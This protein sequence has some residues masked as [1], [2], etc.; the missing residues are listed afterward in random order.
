MPGQ[1]LKKKL[2]I[3][4]QGSKGNEDGLPDDNFKALFQGLEEYA[5][6]FKMHHINGTMT[7]ILTS[8]TQSDLQQMG[9]GSVGHQKILLRRITDIQSTELQSPWPLGE[10]QR[11]R[12]TLRSMRKRVANTWLRCLWRGFLSAEVFL[13]G[14]TSKEETFLMNSGVALFSLLV[15]FAMANW[16]SALRNVFD[17]SGA[18]TILIASENAADI[19]GWALPACHIGFLSGTI[20]SVIGAILAAQSNIMLMQV[21][22]DDFNEFMSN[23]GN[24]AQQLMGTFFFAGLWILLATFVFMAFCTVGWPFN[25]TWICIVLLA[26]VPIWLLTTVRCV[27][28]MYEL[29]NRRMC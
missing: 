19:R 10:A 7:E 1:A 16:A 5:A 23:A 9:I 28:W 26:V 3:S 25:V 12:S 29:A 8:L 4:T 11:R 14:E 6:L 17:Y 21:H 22:Q 18:G 20:C 2:D 27:Y 24:R 15:C 13:V